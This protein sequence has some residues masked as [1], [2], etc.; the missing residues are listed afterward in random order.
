MFGP[1][2]A[3]NRKKILTFQTKAM[4]T[5]SDQLLLLL[6]TINLEAEKEPLT[7]FER[8][9]LKG[10]KDAVQTILDGLQSTNILI[11]I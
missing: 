6:Q 7:D 8:F 9:Y 2:R 1:M 5:I 4:E 11:A 10:K 3:P